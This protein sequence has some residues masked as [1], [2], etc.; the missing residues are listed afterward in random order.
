MPKP[1]IHR[2]LNDSLFYILLRIYLSSLGD[3]FWL[4]LRQKKQ[5][6]KNDYLEMSIYY[7]L[8]CVFMSIVFFCFFFLLNFRWLRQR[9]YFFNIWI[10]TEKISNEFKKKGGSC[11]RRI[12]R[13]TSRAIHSLCTST[14]AKST[15]DLK[16]NCTH[17]LL[18]ILLYCFKLLSF[19][20]NN[21][22]RVIL[23]LCLSLSFFLSFF[24]SLALAISL[25]NSFFY[26]L[27]FSSSIMALYIY[28]NTTIAKAIIIVKED[29][30]RV[31][32]SS[33]LKYKYALISHFICGVAIVSSFS[34]FLQMLIQ[35][36]ACAGYFTC[37]NTKHNNNNNNNKIFNY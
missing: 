21:N 11:D 26:Y 19:I 1:F 23:F 7:L 28:I 30:D 12:F 32:F 31:Y 24:L 36:L 20:I 22:L 25:F 15:F 34:F 13:R 9:N 29:C 33:K 2:N 8:I 16:K 37:N 27:R 17:F 14:Y 6:Q 10:L 18:S 3:I 4:T 5:Q 35:M